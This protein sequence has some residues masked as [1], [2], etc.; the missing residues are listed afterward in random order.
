MSEIAYSTIVYKK[1]LF[2]LKESFKHILDKKIYSNY[3]YHNNKQ[4]VV[5]LN[6]FYKLFIV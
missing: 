2:L 5:T 4:Y 1:T 6:I 3:S